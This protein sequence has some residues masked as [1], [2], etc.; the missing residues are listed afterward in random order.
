VTLSRKTR[1]TMRRGIQVFLSATLAGS[2]A[3]GLGCA[4]SQ[5]TT[6]VPSVN[7]ATLPGTQSNHPAFIDGDP[8]TSGQTTFPENPA[9]AYREITPPSE[10]YVL[11]PG[12]FTI[13]KVRIYSE[14]LV[15]FD[16]FVEDPSQGMKLVG[17][18]DG[19]KGPVIEA[20]MRGVTRASGIRIRV[21]KTINDAE[22]RRKNTRV[23]MFGGRYITGDTRAP[24]TIGEIEVLGA[25]PTTPAETTAAKPSS[26]V[27]SILMSEL[28]PPSRPETT[29]PPT[30]RTPGTPPAPR[31][32]TPS[33][34]PTPLPTTP[35][36]SGKAPAIQLKS[37]RGGAF[38]LDDYYGNVVLVW[39][40]SPSAAGSATLAP[41]LTSLRNELAVEDFEVLGICV[42]ADAEAA[43][44]FLRSHKVGFPNA[45]SDGNVEKAYRVGEALPVTFLISRDGRILKRFDGSPTR[46]MLLPAIRSAL[47]EA[48]PPMPENAPQ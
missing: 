22:T 16:L 36:T 6:A 41:V 9:G 11:L 47:S 10:A 42:G 4:A 35:S 39:F 29:S 28:A 19:Q 13:N 26:E 25:S 23:G 21:R 37:L 46:E 33:T 8:K 31:T 3:W 48:M 34:R 43:N 18:Y 27:G 1:K 24:A 2:V 17:K 32:S 7:L 20:K 40:W 30:T 12:V 44:E 14:D 45:L 38:V 5:L 15:G